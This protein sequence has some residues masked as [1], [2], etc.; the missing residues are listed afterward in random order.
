VVLHHQEIGGSDN[1]ACLISG[2]LFEGLPLLYSPTFGE[3]GFSEVERLKR[4]GTL[5]W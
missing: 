3:G 4:V 5:S 1:E 2:R